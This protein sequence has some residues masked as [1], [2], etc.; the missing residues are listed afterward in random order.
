MILIFMLISLHCTCWL[1]KNDLEMTMKFFC[2]N[3]GYGKYL[4]LSNNSP[5]LEPKTSVLLA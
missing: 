5:T 4:D 3:H 2:Y 1:S